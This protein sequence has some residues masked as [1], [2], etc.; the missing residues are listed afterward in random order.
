[1]L[2]PVKAEFGT[3]LSWSDL[4]VLAGNVALEQAS[5]LNLPFCP[6]RTD[7]A[8]DGG[9]SE[10]LEPRM[11]G[12]FTDTLA[13]LE[14]ASDLLGLTK[15][16]FAVLNAAGYAIGDRYC[17]HGGIFCRRD[18]ASGEPTHLDNRFFKT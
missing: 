10:S 2:W 14:E 4:I 16:E 13:Q 18:M 7:A 8:E 3:G 11:T 1:M 9:A 5:G 12:E 6:G 17:V 15:R